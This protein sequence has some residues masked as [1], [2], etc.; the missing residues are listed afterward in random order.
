MLAEQLQRELQERFPETDSI[1]FKVIQREGEYR[2]IFGKPSGI[3]WAKRSLLVVYGGTPRSEP[4]K[5]ELTI[6]L[7]D[8]QVSGRDAR[9]NLQLT[10]TYKYGVP[11][12]DAGRSYGYVLELQLPYKA[13]SE[14]L[15]KLVPSE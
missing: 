8:M 6:V 2:D 5:M 11:R 3:D 15:V 9:A 12:V 10:V 13:L 7:V 1:Q 4:K 14:S